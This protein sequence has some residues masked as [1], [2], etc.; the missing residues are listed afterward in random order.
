MFT[1][2]VETTGT[3]SAI[4]DQ[5]GGRRLRIDA[6]FEGL[7]E[8]QSIAVEGACLT[9]EDFG[10]GWFSVFLAEETLDRTYFG[11]ISEGD[12]VNLERALPAD[13]RFDGHFVQ[14]HVDATAEILAIEEVGDDW[15]FTFSVPDGQDRYLV[16]KGSIAIDGISL[17]IAARNDD[18]IE[19]AIIPETYDVTTLGEKSV[20]DPVHVEVDVMAKYV[21]RM[22][23]ADD[24]QPGWVERA[25]EE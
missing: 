12:G 23:Q 2:I 13:G 18:S 9:V 3:V 16:E 19:V 5:A 10:E 7:T 24:Q 1:G 8:G 11:T 6:P 22:L 4:D 14:G 25:A 17:T 15:R 21:E 20:G